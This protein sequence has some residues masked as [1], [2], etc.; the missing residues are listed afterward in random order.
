MLPVLSA[1]SP[2][3]QDALCAHFIGNL[4]LK[5]H[6]HSWHNTLPLFC[7]L[8]YTCPSSIHQTLATQDEAIETKIWQYVLE[9]RSSSAR[10]SKGG[11]LTKVTVSKSL[12]FFY[13]LEICVN[14]EKPT[15]VNLIAVDGLPDQVNFLATKTALSTYCIT[16]NTM[17]LTP[18]FRKHTEVVISC[19]YKRVT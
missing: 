5:P 10:K 8:L 14:G 7:H 4:N 9:S 2:I 15:A 12:F 11:Q 18:W 17:P 16:Q 3:S 19:T 13:A 6:P 1:S